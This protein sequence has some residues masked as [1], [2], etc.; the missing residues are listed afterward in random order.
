MAETAPTIDTVLRPG[1]RPLPAARVPHSAE[2]LGEVSA[3]LTVG[4]HVVTR[5]RSSRRSW[6]RREDDRASQ[7]LPVGLD[8]VRRGS[9]RGP[10]GDDRRAPRT[11]S[12]PSTA[13]RRSAARLARRSRGDEAVAD[14]AARADRRQRTS[15]PR[16]RVF[17]AARARGPPRGH[18]RLATLH[19]GGPWRSTQ[20]QARRAHRCS[21]ASVGGVDSLPGDRSRS[22]ALVR[23]APRPRRGR[24]VAAEPRSRRS[25]AAWPHARALRPRPSGA[26]TRSSPPRRPPSG[27]CSSR[28]PARGAGTHCASR[29][30]STSDRRGAARAVP[31]RGCAA[32]AHPPGASGPT[33]RGA[34]RSPTHDPARRRRGG[35]RSTTTTSSPTSTPARPPG[36]PTTHRVP[37]LHARPARPLLRRTR[38]AG[39]RRAH[40]GISRADVAVLAR[41]RRPLRGERRDPPARPVLRAGDARRRGRHRPPAPRGGASRSSRSAGARA[42]PAGEQAAQHFARLGFGIEAIDA[43]QPLERRRRRGRER[44]RTARRGRRRRDGRP[45]RE[46]ESAPIPR[47]TCGARIA[48]PMREWELVGIEA[49]RQ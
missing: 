41:R 19:P 23:Q 49:R 42:S 3:H 4:I 1:R 44:R 20:A 11:A 43:L 12:G 28:S 46:H 9:G 6:R 24:P 10:R 2:A 14:R 13:G 18:R 40:R 22:L 16:R 15:R 33:S 21:T 8:L 34:G 25:I 48:T 17:A 31:L 29:G 35:A 36:T 5:R 30:S 39:R 32:P 47:L 38:L 27:S 26:A 37:R 7:A 45:L